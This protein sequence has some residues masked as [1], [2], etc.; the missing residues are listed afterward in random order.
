MFF[1]AIIWPVFNIV[2]NLFFAFAAL[3]SGAANYVA[4]WWVLLTLLD[5]AAAL[6]TIAMEEEDLSLVPYALLYRLFFVAMIDVVKLF[7]TAEEFLNV[8]MSWGK[9]ERVGR[10]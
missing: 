3:G 1:E 5:V 9:L 10:I 8:R 2:G 4:W 7:A 6:H